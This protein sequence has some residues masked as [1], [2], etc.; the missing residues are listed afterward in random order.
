MVN[1]FAPFITRF[2]K[3]RCRNV[4]FEGL[5]DSNRFFKARENS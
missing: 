4:Y 5:V 3:L 2:I 1:M